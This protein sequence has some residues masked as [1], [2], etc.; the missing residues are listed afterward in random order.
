MELTLNR[1]FLGSSATIGELLINDK[2][3]CDTLE[4]RVRPEGEKVYGKTAIPEGTY[5]VKLTHSPRFKKI[6]PEILNVPN[7]SGIRIHTGNSSKDTEGCILVGTWD[8]E[9]ED[10]VGSSKI[11]FDELMTLLEEA[12]NN[13]EKITI[14]VKSLLD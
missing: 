7:F 4:D 2:H 1:I 14:T 10:W 12:T 3:L 8:G 6:L 9:K 5:E 11:A 13:K